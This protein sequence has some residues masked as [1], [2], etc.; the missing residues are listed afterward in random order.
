MSEGKWHQQVMP[1]IIFPYILSTLILSE[2]GGTVVRWVT[3]GR[4]VARS[5]GGWHGWKVGG[6]V[7]RWVARSEGGWHGR[8]VKC[9]YIYALLVLILSDGWVAWASR[10]AEVGTPPISITAVLALPEVG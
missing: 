10:N 1:Q 7:R 6:M 4:W 8:V 9:H 5:E 2:G 3:V